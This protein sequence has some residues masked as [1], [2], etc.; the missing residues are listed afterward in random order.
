MAANVNADAFIPQIWNASIIRTLED[1]L[2]AR[3]I[4]R[5]VPAVRAKGA[6]DTVYF[7]GLADP[8]I[9]DYSGSLT[10]E[11][12]VSSQV[13]L[14]IDQQKSYSFKVT[15]V[16]AMMANVD[17]KGSQVERASYGLRKAVDTYIFGSATAPAV[18]DA[19]H[20]LTAD[21][22]CDSTTILGD[23]SE[24]GRVLE[25]QNV[26]E[27]NKWI[28]VPPWVKEKLILAGVKFQIN[29]GING[30]GGMSWANYLDM[31]IYVSNNLY[32]SGTAAAPV[33]TVIGGSYDAIV[34]EDVLNKARV[35][36]LEDGFEMGCSGLL[37]FGAKV[38]KPNELVKRVLTYTAESSI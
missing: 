22:T 21:T 18:A 37:V 5:A 32:N 12:L 34:Y 17:L 9:S 10:Y 24:F 8:T 28:V 7:N 23:I 1:N 16:E 36:E 31:D 27:G 19:G 38:V 6:G 26:M 25:E 15:D 30:T 11:T 14:L 3:K 2:I 4:T 33:T 20:T 35:M 13:A 29:N